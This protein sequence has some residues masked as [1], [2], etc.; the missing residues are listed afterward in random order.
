MNPTS[1]VRATIPRAALIVGTTL[2]LLEA[3]K[4]TTFSA[5]APAIRAFDSAGYWQ[6]GQQV[7]AGDIWMVR[8]PIAYRTPAYPW[9]L[10]AVQFLCGRSSWQ[11][12][13]AIQY[14]AVWLTTVLT[15]WWTWKVTGRPWLAVLALAICL[16]SAARP[17]FASVLLTETFFTL[18]LTLTICLLT[19][20]RQGPGSPR[21]MA[22]SSIVWGLSWLLRP[23][24]AALVP[25]WLVACWLSGSDQSRGKWR[26]RFANVVITVSVLLF[27]LGPWVARNVYLFQRA[28]LTVFLGRELWITT[29]GPGQP[30]ALPL[31]ETDTAR[32]LQEIVLRGG[33]F[34][35]WDGNWTVSFRLTDGGLSD[36]DADELMRDVS[37]QA[38]MRNPPHAIARGIWR[39]VDFWRSVYSR[40]M[41]FYE[42]TSERDP[43]P[44]QMWNQPQ[45]QSFRDA[46]LNQTWESRL[47]GIE[48]TSL[49]AL[50]GLAGLWL[51]PHTWRFGAIVTAAILG[52]GILTAAVEYPSYRYR[53][54]L[55]PTMIV[56]AVAGWSVIANVIIRG[57]KS[58]WQDA[59]R[60][61]PH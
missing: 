47:L 54:V 14:V 10:G 23:A 41:S 45:C 26:S 1:N 24:A 19:R 53:M 3:I 28:S 57:T 20:E 43:D 51:G 36:V 34:T 22:L 59:S 5:S 17:S 55:E 16:G 32:R 52:V 60:C 48:L 37:L 31:P 11:I 33:K 39:A 44:G 9:F 18:F 7:A 38:I 2:C 13:V 50:I 61:D 15:G 27:V 35:G 42:E 4:L 49:L 56:S 21:A 40:P 8:N 30:A 29:F 12:M 46:W 58:L 6:L 25:A